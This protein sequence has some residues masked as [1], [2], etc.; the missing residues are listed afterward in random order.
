LYQ[1]EVKQMDEG[2][3]K[4]TSQL[5]NDGECCS[6]VIA[7]LGLK[8]KNEDSE[9]LVSAARALCLG[10]RSGMTCGALTGSVCVLGLFDP[11][12][13]E[14]IQAMTDWFKDNYG[15]EDTSCSCL[16]LTKGDA[17]V[18]RTVCPTIVS[19]SFDRVKKLLQEY[20]YIEN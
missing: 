2:E 1:Q 5:L 17:S 20:G 18:R 15:G 4:L 7:R 3:K 6:A 13:T 9:Q 12:N 16:S 11:H 14:M 8:L 19:D 10:M